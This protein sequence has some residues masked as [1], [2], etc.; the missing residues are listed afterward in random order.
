MIKETKIGTKIFIEQTTYY[1]YESE[2]HRM[3]DKA[4]ISTSDKKAFDKV[5]KQAIASSKKVLTD[6][7]KLYAE[8]YDKVYSYKTKYPQ[9]FVA[10]EIEELLKSYPDIDM[11]RFDDAMMGNTCMVS[12]DNQAIIYHC[13]IEKALLCGIEKRGLRFYEWD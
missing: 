9:G 5:R 11:K 2:A 3:N 7:E 12:P 1:V 6:Q 8:V 4:T 10:S 13:D